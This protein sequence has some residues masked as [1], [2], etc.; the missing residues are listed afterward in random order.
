MNKEQ[1]IQA[2][3]CCVLKNRNCLECP[4]D[5]IGGCQCIDRVKLDALEL[6]M[7]QD[8]K[9]FELENRLKENEN[10]YAQ[11]LHMEKCKNAELTKENESLAKSVN[12][13][14][15]LIRKKN[16]EIE[17]MKNCLTLTVKLDDEQIEKIKKN[18]W[19]LLRLT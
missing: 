14:S 10:G 8:Q 17:R 18:V 2:F 7:A 12:E 5:H 16:A 11:T 15:E 3:K 1:I 4:Y 13:A 19:H 9:I 6:I